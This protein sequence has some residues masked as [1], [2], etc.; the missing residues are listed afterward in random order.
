MWYILFKFFEVNLWLEWIWIWCLSGNVV[1]FLMLG[2]VVWVRW[3]IC[4]ISLLFLLK[5]YSLLFDILGGC[6]GGL[7]LCVNVLD[8]GDGIELRLERGELVV[9]V[10]VGD[11]L[12]IFV[13]LVLSLEVVVFIICVGGDILDC[14]VVIWMF[15]I[16]M[17]VF[18]DVVFW[19]FIWLGDLKMVGLVFFWF[20][21][22]VV[23]VVVWGGVVF[24]I[25]MF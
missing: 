12:L 2:E 3:C 23:L 9:F 4:F 5:M 1:I 10:R 16:F 18:W 25:L 17:F 13:E 15:D 11:L 14:F 24:F 6:L 22:I 7:F 21:I 19:V 8:G 20:R